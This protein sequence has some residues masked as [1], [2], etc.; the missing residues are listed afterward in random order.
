MGTVSSQELTDPDG[1]TVEN[2]L[3]RSPAAR[4]TRT[5]LICLSRAHNKF[6]ITTYQELAKDGK[7]PNNILIS[8]LC[9]GLGFGMI[10]LGAEGHT[11]DE[12]YNAFHLD[13]VQEYHLLSAYAAVDWDILRSAMPKGCI[14]E[15]AIRLFAHLDYKMCST[16]EH[17]CINYEI[18][19]LKPLDFYGRPDLARRE[20]NKWVEDRTQGR[21]KDVLPLGIIDR[22]TR[23]FLISAVH[24]KV[25]WYHPFDVK[26][27]RKMA[28]YLTMKE[29]LEVQMMNQQNSFRIGYLPKHD[30][31]VLELPFSNV[32]LKMYIFLPR[33]ADG[34]RK[35]EDKLNRALIETLE[36]NIQEEYIDV[37]LPKFVHEIGWPP[38]DPIMKAGIKVVFKQEKADL[39]GIDGSNDL[40]LKNVFHYVYIEVDESGDDE[41]KG[42]SSHHHHDVGTSRPDI[43]PQRIFKADHPFCFYLRDDRTGA[44]LFMG[45]IVRPVLAL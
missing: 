24:L 23:L 44:I 3:P 16:Y 25:H 14:L 37:F 7:K 27:T 33:K 15:V 2:D 26:N 35:F 28:F 10:Y 4:T 41:F 17:L 21:I 34:I 39:S 45:R 19:R 8:P 9:L 6:A 1:V 32:H 40:F 31:D 12:L 5:H 36:D 43:R 13:E 22:D 11:K 38:K 20:I 18:S 30:C 29:T 42:V